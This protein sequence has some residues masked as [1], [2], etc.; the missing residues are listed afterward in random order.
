MRPTAKFCILQLQV[1]SHVPF[2]A[3]EE[4]EAAV[5]VVE[6]MIRDY[7]SLFSQRKRG[8]SLFAPS[9]DADGTA[10]PAALVA[11]E[12]AER[13]PS[14]AAAVVVPLRQP[15]SPSKVPAALSAGA[16]SVQSCV[17][18]RRLQSGWLW[19][20]NALPAVSVP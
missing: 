6:H 12:R 17:A 2:C 4:R 20:S 1:S 11:A 3:Q 9:D 13:I 5:A 15:L 18:M 10:A 7:R 19:C 16:S 14:V 8:R